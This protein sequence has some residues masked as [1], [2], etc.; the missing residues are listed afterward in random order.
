VRTPAGGGGHVADTTAR[1]RLDTAEL[2]GALGCLDQA[3][4]RLTR[5]AAAVRRLEG[6]LELSETRLAYMATA[7][8]EAIEDGERALRSLREGR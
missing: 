1:P 6:D 5:L 7:V 8:Q 3:L 2:E 4:A